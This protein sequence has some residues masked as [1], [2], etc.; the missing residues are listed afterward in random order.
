MFSRIG[1]AIAAIQQVQGVGYIGKWRLE[2]G[3]GGVVAFADIAAARLTDPLAYRL[4]AMMAVGD[5]RM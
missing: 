2:M 4:N 1:L 3:H 5:K